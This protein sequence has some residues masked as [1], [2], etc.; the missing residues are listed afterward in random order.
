MNRELAMRRLAP[1]AAVLLLAALAGCGSDSCPTDT[2]PC[3]CDARYPVKVGNRWRYSMLDSMFNYRPASGALLDE[4]RRTVRTVDVAR[5]ENLEGGIFAHV[6]AESMPDFYG[7]IYACED[8]YADEARGLYLI[9]HRNAPRVTP[10]ASRALEFGGRIF[11][12]VHEIAASIMRGVA[13]HG[14]QYDSLIYEEDPPLTLKYPLADGSTWVYRKRGDPWLVKREIQGTEA[15]SV[16]AGEFECY[17]VAW[18]VDVDDDGEWDG[19]AEFVDYI[20]TQGLIRR[21]LFIKDMAMRDVEGTI[22]G[23][24]DALEQSDLTEYSLR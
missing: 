19:D 4:S 14:V 11:G 23:Y 13:W 12:S 21:R 15:V 8:Y 10:F 1:A 9:A 20:S 16:P 17:K 22:I 6:F 7:G 3:F 18:L 24:V 2:C 5:T